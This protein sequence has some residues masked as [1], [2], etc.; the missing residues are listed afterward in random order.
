M[1]VYAIHFM[2]FIPKQQGLKIIFEADGTAAV[3]SELPMD[4]D[5]DIEGTVKCK[6]KYSTIKT[7]S[8]SH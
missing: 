3:F 2:K 1:C 6:S 4:I 5:G 7:S 8:Y